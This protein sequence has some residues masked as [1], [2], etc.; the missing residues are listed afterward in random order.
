MSNYNNVNG[1]SGSGTPS[2]DGSGLRP[3]GQLRCATGLTRTSTS[4][5]QESSHNGVGERVH[6]KQASQVAHEAT[7]GI[8]QALH[9]LG[10]G[11]NL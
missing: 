4:S 11:L 7:Q 3:S 9:L 6:D 1:G 8:L 5:S 10:H 2:S